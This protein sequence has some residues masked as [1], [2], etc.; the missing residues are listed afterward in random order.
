VLHYEV[1]QTSIKLVGLNTGT[2]LLVPPSLCHSTAP[3][4]KRSESRVLL[5]KREER[6]LGNVKGLGYLNIATAFFIDL[7]DSF[8]VRVIRL[9]CHSCRYRCSLAD[10]GKSRDRPV[11][12]TYLARPR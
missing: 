10:L 7:G 5:H 8:P 9:R 12:D 1:K 11:L 2:S 3:L 6:R 4:Y